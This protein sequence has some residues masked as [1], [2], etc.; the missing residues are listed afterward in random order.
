VATKTEF[1][2][3]SC[4]EAT[5]NASPNEVSS[6][7]S[8]KLGAQTFIEVINSPNMKLNRLRFISFFLCR[9]VLIALTLIAT[10]VKA[11]RLPIKIYTSADGLGSSFVDYMIRD[12]RGF[13]W[14]CTRDGVS[15][16]D[17]VSF[18][19]YLIGSENTTT[20][21]E[22]ILETKK[23]VYWFVTK[24]GLSR[25]DP[26]T[27]PPSVQSAAD[28][29]GRV[30]LNVE[31][32]SNIIGYLYEDHDGKLW[33]YSGQHIYLIQERDDKATLQSSPFVWP[34]EI[35]PSSV[36]VMLQ[37][38]DGSHWFNT[39]SGLLRRLPDGRIV[40]FQ[41]QSLARF[42]DV[43]FHI[44]ED[45][46][47]RIWLAHNSGLFVINPE[48]PSMLSSLGQ[49]T[50]RDLKANRVFHIKPRESVSL[51][52]KQGEMFQYIGD[53]SLFGQN[54]RRFY[55]TSDKHIWVTTDQ[56]L[57][58]FDGQDFRSYTTAQGLSSGL[59]GSMVEDPN[60]NLW[61]SGYNGAIR[62]EHAGL[63]AFDTKDGLGST[64][65]HSIYESR[66]GELF[67]INGDG[68]I[69]RFDGKAFQ[70]VKLSL[71]SDERFLWTSNGVFLD[72]QK[73][74]WALTNKR[75]YR[76]P[77]V[78]NFEQ[79]TTL[80]P[81]A[82][83][84]SRDGLPSD[85][86]FRMFE[87]SR[88][89]LWI[90]TN[91]QTSKDG[92]VR[93]I[94]TEQRFQQFTEADGFPVGLAASSFAEDRAGN[95]WFGFYNGDAARYS[96]GRFTILTTKDRLP[97]GFITAIYLDHIGRL[98][99][100]SSIGGLARVDDPTAEQPDFIHYTIANGL[101]SNNVRSITEDVQGRIYVGTARGVDRITPETGHIR[102]YTIN[103]GLPADLVG[104]AMRDRYGA[105]WFGTPDGLARL[106]PE[107]DK[108][109]AESP[110]WLSGL[111]I[112]GEP[113]PL[114]QFG[115]ADIAN[116]E[117]SNSQNNLQIDFFGLDFSSSEKL[118]YQ[119]MLEGADKEWSVPTEQRTVHYANLSPGTY[120]FMVRTV[121]ATN[122]AR[123]KLAI[124]SFRIFP[125]IW[126]RW[127]FI[128]SITLLISL[129]GYAFIRSRLESNRALQ[130]EREERLREL[131]RVRTRIAT[132][133]H[134]DIGTSLTQI[135]VL[136]EVVRQK[137]DQNGKQVGE[138]L[139]KISSVSNE[140]VETMSDI[141]W[142]IN[143]HKDH[144]SDLVQRMRRFAS[145]VLASRQI[146][147]R[148]NVPA[149]KTEALLGANIRREVFLIFKE[150][151]NNIT[152]H[153]NCSTVEV[154]FKTEGD[155]LT[156][157]IKDDGC[158]FDTSRLSDDNSLA[159]SNGKGGNGLPNMKRRAQELGG[160]FSIESKSNEG[161][162]VTLRVPLIRAEAKEKKGVGE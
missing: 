105:L 1:W 21:V 47:G 59:L 23:G 70:T 77:S 30:R 127:W 78:N 150:S 20:G 134:D 50:K 100:A 55:Q 42:A 69:S 36:R 118:R 117:L 83:Y 99:F 45:N 88:G 137:A 104:W 79:L 37:G 19:T 61:I 15:R 60:G 159:T 152:K 115:S 93:W 119:Y 126:R 66:L 57:V 44:I 4:H 111:R 87:D 85:S 124:V 3:I 71:P 68:F 38:K 130:Q 123:T 14:F 102:H 131:E 156:L 110:V 31:L 162:I 81:I 90:S 132:D 107:P 125:P 7:T 136:S 73:G 91:A 86:M 39:S 154:D 5:R 53:G 62:L 28:G 121:N 13:L 122:T 43:N 97:A 155:W 116:L 48:S 149:F 72:H 142:A 128:A 135:A 112:A 56:G 108:T 25:F 146:A 139:K 89:D 22:F 113:Q 84:N 95:L 161:T 58:N 145:D 12:S 75:L 103:N 153:A 54:I 140:L 63:T 98:W 11:E 65:I 74:W 114:A 147:F 143:P 34:K 148:F 10:T 160:A 96:N 46:E 29:D 133:L 144:L 9:L 2:S 32:V 92:L 82:A 106:I 151:V 94:R 26:N 16:F 49:Y 52:D 27:A 76:F 109:P 41:G 17:G 8:S 129:I 101:S 67:V 64:R 120:R 157:Q 24:A 138:P 80:A 35:E 141:V 33:Y 6:A 51:P 18:T 40:N 158:G